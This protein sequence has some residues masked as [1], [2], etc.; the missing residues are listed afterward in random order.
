MA[1]A[2]LFNKLKKEY[3][4]YYVS[5]HRIIAVANEALASSKQAIFAMHRD[6]IKDAEKLLALAEKKLKSLKKYFVQNFFL[7]DEGAYR[8]AIE[9]YV[10]AK[11]FWQVLTTGKIDFIKTVNLYFSGYLGGLCDLT[12]ELLRKMILLATAGKFKE[13]GKLKDLM[14]DIVAE[15]I[16]FN[17]TG[18]LR[19]KYDG[20]K[21]NL[22]KAEE[23][24][25]EI[26]M[27]SRQ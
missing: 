1:K 24:L 27:K 2:Q 8:A 21:N 25:Y 19:N 14:A 23:I 3:D 5:R 7:E 15:L 4:H 18:Y 17:L 20:A 12:G 16:K 9:E 13:A 11:L 6:D 22:R 26:K 10:E